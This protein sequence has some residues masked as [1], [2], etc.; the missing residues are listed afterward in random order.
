MFK[1]GIERRI[2]RRRKVSNKQK[3]QTSVPIPIAEPSFILSYT[4][5][6]LLTCF[7]HETCLKGHFYIANPCTGIERRIGRRRKVSNKQ[8]QQKT[9]WTGVSKLVY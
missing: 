2:G 1:T 3:Q 4:F 6:C 9:T 8:K 5:Y 7:R